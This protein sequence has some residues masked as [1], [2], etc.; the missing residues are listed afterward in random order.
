MRMEEKEKKGD[1]IEVVSLRFF[2]YMFKDHE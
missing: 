2:R 1:R